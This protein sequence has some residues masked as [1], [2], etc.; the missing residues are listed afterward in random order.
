MG[1]AAA[2]LTAV[3]NRLAKIRPQDYPAQFEVV[4]AQMGQSVA[5][6]FESTLYTIL[7]AVG[8]LLLIGC[9]NVA[10]LMLVRANVRMKEFAIRFSLGA[11]RMRMTRQLLTESLTLAILGGLVGVLAGYAD[12]T[13]ILWKADLQ[14]GLHTFRGQAAG[15]ESV[16]FDRAGYRYHGRIKALADAAREAGL[17]F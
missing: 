5:G 4:V 14:A 8:L 13:A 6:H 7:A 11:G 9:V 15:I 12:G 17:K 3:A 10:N 16:A 1:Q 2:D